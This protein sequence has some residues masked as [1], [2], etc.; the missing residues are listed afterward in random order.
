MPGT[1]EV[2]GAVGVPL[3][4]ELRRMV[5]VRRH[6]ARPVVTPSSMTADS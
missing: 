6:V 5:G 3:N 1:F 2:S 4:A